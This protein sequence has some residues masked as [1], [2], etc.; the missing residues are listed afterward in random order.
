MIYGII[1]ARA[2]SKRVA[3]KNL[4]VVAGHPLMA[5]TLAAAKRAAWID[6]V[7]VSTEDA[8]TAT[9]ARYYGASVIDRPPELSHDDATQEQVLEHAYEWVGC[10]HDDA[11]VLLQPTSPLRR[12]D[13]IDAAITI[14][15]EGNFDSLVSVVRDPK[16]YFSGAV[17]TDG[18]WDP[19]YRDRPDTKECQIWRENGAIFTATWFAFLSSGDRLAYR[20]GA[21]EMS[22]EDSLDID[23]EYDLEIADW[24]IGREL[25]RRSPRMET[26]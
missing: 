26:P 2:G 10:G 5:W 20:C 24:R 22:E 9:V 25:L 13:H 3:R 14:M 1:P 12:A 19:D 15:N 11:F 8:E 6:E 18:F 23:T 21:Y 4:R 16:I 17:E 7:W